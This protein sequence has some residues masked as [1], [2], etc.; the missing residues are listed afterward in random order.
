MIIRCSILGLYPDETELELRFNDQKRYSC[1]DWQ[2]T[3]V[4]TD[5]RSK[6]PYIVR[7]SDGITCELHIPASTDSFNGE[8]YCRGEILTDESKCLFVQSQRIPVETFGSDEINTAP[9]NSTSSGDMS[10]RGDVII[11]T[12]TAIVTALATTVVV[13]ATVMISFYTYKHCLRKNH[14]ETTSEDP[15]QPDQVPQR[16]LH[17]SRERQ[18]GERTP[19]VSG[20][21]TA[22]SSKR[23]PG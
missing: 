16:D 9:V 5:E 23:G 7:S 15:Q 19:L 18:A 22:R 6:T 1:D 4:T 12:I 2:P 11:V 10:I 3:V 17:T 20:D 8:Y 13:L 21:H 14:Q